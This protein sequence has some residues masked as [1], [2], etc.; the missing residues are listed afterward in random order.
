MTDEQGSFVYA[1]NAPPRALAPNKATR[2]AVE[3][4]RRWF[5]RHPARTI[6]LRNPAPGEV[7]HLTAGTE[8]EY[9]PVEGGYPLRV[10]VVRLAPD[11]RAR[12]LLY[13]NLPDDTPEP[14][15]EGFLRLVELATE[16]GYE[17]EL[18]KADLGAMLGIPGAGV[19][20]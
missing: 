7:E 18:S 4:D 1:R 14:I 11:I 2:R 16:Q 3:D 15:L 6:R 13:S 20:H 5:L 8:V 17:G 10:F 19:R 12:Q 9:P